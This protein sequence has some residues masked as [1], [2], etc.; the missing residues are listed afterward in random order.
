MSDAIV[1]GRGVGRCIRDPQTT[2]A[3]LVLFFSFFFF[4]YMLERNPLNPRV[5]VQLKRKRTGYK[6]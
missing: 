3:F 6:M 2:I 1:C 4:L 5:P